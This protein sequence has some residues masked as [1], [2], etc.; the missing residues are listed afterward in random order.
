MSSLVPIKPTFH[1]F[2]FSPSCRTCKF[3]IKKEWNYLDKCTL[4]RNL[5]SKENQIPAVYVYEYS[6]HCRKSE[7][8]CGKM[9]NYFELDDLNNTK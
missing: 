3:N 5:I 7:H 6:S 9:A 4:F 2:D 8:L 1:R